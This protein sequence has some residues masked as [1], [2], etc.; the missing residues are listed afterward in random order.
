VGGTLYYTN[1]V[2]EEANSGEI[3]VI[4]S[5]LRDFIEWQRR[6][7]GSHQRSNRFTV[8]SKTYY[9]IISE[10]DLRGIRLTKAIMLEGAYENRDLDRIISTI[11][12]NLS[13]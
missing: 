3:G 12:V 5:R 2:V 10:N 13:Y 4:C 1:G 8:G 6:I 7:G 11:H 9:C